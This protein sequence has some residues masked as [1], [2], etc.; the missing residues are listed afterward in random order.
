MTDVEKIINLAKQQIEN[1]AS[2]YRVWFYGYNATDVAWCAIFISWL[3]SQAGINMVKTDGAGCFAREGN[4]TYGTWYESEFSDSS[5]TPKIG[6]I[7]TF[8]WNYAGRYYQNDKYY[9]DHVG[10]VYAV[11]NN[12]IYTIEGNAGASND[13]STVKY[14]S[15]SRTSG[16]INGY[17]RPNYDTAEKEEKQEV[18]KMNNLQKGDIG[19]SVL[20]YKTL[21]AQAYTFRLINTKVDN[22]NGFGSGTH[23]ATLEF[24]K[25]YKLEEDG[26]AGVKTITALKEAVNNKI[27]TAMK[28][29]NA[30][31][32]DLAKKLNEM[33]V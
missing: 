19:D 33:K 18:R 31:I 30:L 22:T 10:I 16:A 8:V 1:G 32:D 20:A 28:G 7:V 27:E 23:K 9:S 17:F 25:L 29:H 15:Y 3:F 2:K 4:G 21:L 14:K 26:I 12:N 5:T 11:D 6:D 13:T 24:Q